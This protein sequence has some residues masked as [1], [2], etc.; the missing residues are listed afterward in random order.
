MKYK[1]TN[2]KEWIYERFGNNEKYIIE[3]HKEHAEYS[4]RSTNK[5]IKTRVFFS[6]MNNEDDEVLYDIQ[7]SRGNEEKDYRWASTFT[8]EKEYKASL[9]EQLKA[10]TMLQTSLFYNEKFI[11]RLEKEWISIPL[12]FGWTEELWFVGEKLYKAKLKHNGNFNRNINEKVS[13]Y[14]NEWDRLKLLFG[15]GKSSNVTKIEKIG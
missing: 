3:F 13:Y 10:G 7:F 11:T 14:L 5:N 15:I 4:I 2:W 1:S 6:F 8:A 12:K 9:L